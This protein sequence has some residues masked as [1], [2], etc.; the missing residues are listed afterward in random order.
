MDKTIKILGICGSHVKGGNTEH[1]LRKA[2]EAVENEEHVLTEI[3][4]L[5]GKKFS[6]CVHCNWCIN[7]QRKDKYCALNDDLEEIFPKVLEADGLL[8]ATPVYLGRLTGLLGSF[9]DRMRVFAEGAYYHGSLKNKV[10]GALAVAWFRHGGI[11]SA[12]LSIL[13][14]FLLMQ[15]IPA[16]VPGVGALYGAGAVSSI[17]GEGTFD[18]EKRLAV[19][20]DEL[21]LKGAKAILK[22]MIELVRLTRYGTENGVL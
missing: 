15:M 5:S 6:G 14:G 11:E 4:N 8:L 16:S 12:L 9:M 17:R 20:E 2:L 22:R 3:Y 19:L 10:G 1:F 7:K 21:G 18:P 13:Y